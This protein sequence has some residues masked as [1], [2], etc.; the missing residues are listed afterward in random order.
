MFPF[1]VLYQCLN[2]MPFE[3]Q[4]ELNEIQF[5]NKLKHPV[6]DKFN[7]IHFLADIDRFL[8][9]LYLNKKIM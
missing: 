9:E 3:I 1:K 5:E 4:F 7:E 8:P 2:M 6:R